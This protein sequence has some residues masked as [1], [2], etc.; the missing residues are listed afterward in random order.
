MLRAY[1]ASATTIERTTLDTERLEQWR[2]HR[3]AHSAYLV[4]DLRGTHSISSL[5]NVKVVNDTMS[6]A[7]KENEVSAENATVRFLFDLNANVE[8]LQKKCAK[9]K[10]NTPHSWFRVGVNDIKGQSDPME[11]LKL[12]KRVVL[13]QTCGNI[14]VTN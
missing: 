4:K 2:T 1:G 8:F 11:L 9:C 3:G 13:C 14:S 6:E 10:T 5:T 12:A 7:Q